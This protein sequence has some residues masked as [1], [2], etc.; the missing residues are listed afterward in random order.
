MSFLLIWGAQPSGPMSDPSSTKIGHCQGR[1]DSK[2]KRPSKRD[3]G[4]SWGPSLPIPFLSCLLGLADLLTG[5]KD[6]AKIQ[7]PCPPGQKELA[8]LVSGRSPY[9]N[10]TFLQPHAR[11]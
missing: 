9:R 1:R 5:S 2:G 3:V 10:V 6:A 7:S 4:R 8:P 11:Q